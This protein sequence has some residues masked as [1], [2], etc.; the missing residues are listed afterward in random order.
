M[1]SEKCALQV[2]VE[3]M[4]QAD[5]ADILPIERASFKAPWTVGMFLD[6]LKTPH[7][8]CLVAKL[9]RE[10]QTMICAY[11]VFW[12]VADEAHLHKV[13]V[14]KEYRRQGLA[15][16]LMKAMEDIARQAGIA[17]QMLEVRES[18]VGAISLY[19]Q[20]GFVVKGK[21]P[22]YYD[23]TPEAACVMWKEY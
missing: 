22:N 12:L 23:D 18:N 14:K 16:G 4:R 19:C 2:F 3:P 7:S 1:F 17:K 20:C 15:S 8:H 13:A 6:E 21:R 9:A 10:N 11:I 5:L